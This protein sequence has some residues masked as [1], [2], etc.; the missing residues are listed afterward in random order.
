MTRDN[1][2]TLFAISWL[3]MLF[4]IMLGGRYGAYN[5]SI[6]IISPL[7]NDPNWVVYLPVQSGRAYAKETPDSQSETKEVDQVS[8]WVSQYADKFTNTPTQESKMKYQ[9]HCLLYFESKHTAAK[10]CGDNSK[11]CGALQYHEPTWYGFREIMFKRGL[12]KTIGDRM[13]VEQAIETTSWAISD[14]RIMSWG[15]AANSGKCL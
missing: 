9:L 2:I 3:L 13:N 11:A 7:P 1:K 14:G 5:Q 8:Q 6:S 15:P 10:G 4:T 12:I